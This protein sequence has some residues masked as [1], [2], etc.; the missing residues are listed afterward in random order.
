MFGNIL[1]Y[2]LQEDR[3]FF[4]VFTYFSLSLLMYALFLSLSPFFFIVNSSEIILLLT[5]Q[6]TH[7]FPRTQVELGYG[8]YKQKRKWEIKDIKYII[9]QTDISGWSCSD[10]ACRIFIKSKAIRDAHANVHPVGI[11][12]VSI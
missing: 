3:Y 8:T 4:M 9:F 10:S 7:C 2:C 1:F 11:N 5:E 6:K 12:I